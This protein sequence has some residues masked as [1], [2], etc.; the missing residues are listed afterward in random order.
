MHVY[1][2]C[3]FEDATVGELFREICAGEH[4]LNDVSSIKTVHAVRPNHGSLFLD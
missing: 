3:F 1:T 4:R 2:I